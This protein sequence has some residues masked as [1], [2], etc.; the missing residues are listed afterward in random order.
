MSDHPAGY[1]DE[2]TRSRR[3]AVLRILKENEGAANE[4]VLRVALHQLGF[5]GRLAG[6]DAIRQDA[7]MLTAAGLATV[8]YY[9]G[10]VMTLS[11]TRRGLSYLDRHLEPIPGIA[12]PSIA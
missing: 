1:A 7:D 2:T 3:L 8:E 6:D 5:R 9:R 11:I 12:Y 10:A 4:S